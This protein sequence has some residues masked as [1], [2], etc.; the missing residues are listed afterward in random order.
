MNIDPDRAR[1]LA[2]WL[3]QNRSKIMHEVR[4]TLFH[5]DTDNSSMLPYYAAILGKIEGLCTA[6]ERQLWT[7]LDQWGTPDS[8][9]ELNDEARAAAEAAYR[10]A[11]L[12]S[13]R[14]LL[15]SQPPSQ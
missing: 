13:M 5:Y 12:E 6:F 11:Y 3:K 9:C 1:R 15:E 4:Q 7:A 2:E 10:Q 14:A 8:F